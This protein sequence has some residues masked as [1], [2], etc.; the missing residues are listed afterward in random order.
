MGSE[1]GMVL[2]EMTAHDD[3]ARTGIESPFSHTKPVGLT[4]L[5][6]AFHHIS[7]CSFGMV[8]FLLVNVI[9][10]VW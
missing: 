3:S 10:N 9:H 8:F 5:V 6:Y 4:F 2:R 1:K 7:N